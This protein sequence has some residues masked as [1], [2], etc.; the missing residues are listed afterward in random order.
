VAAVRPSANPARRGAATE[1]RLRILGLPISS[2]LV[3][4]V[5]PSIIVLY[6]LYYCWQVS[7]GRRD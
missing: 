6:Q 3:L 4:I 2:F 7:T 5:I 1:V